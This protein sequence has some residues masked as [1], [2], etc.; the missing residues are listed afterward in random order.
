[1]LERGDDFSAKVLYSN[2]AHFHLD[3]YGAVYGSVASFLFF[4]DVEENTITA[5]GVLYRDRITHFVAAI[6]L[7]NETFSNRIISCNSEWIAF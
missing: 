1:M 6:A 5:N 3:G 2:E 7:L 4:E